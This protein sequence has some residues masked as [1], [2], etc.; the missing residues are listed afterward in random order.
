MSAKILEDLSVLTTIPL[1]SLQRLID[2]SESCICHAVAEDMMQKEPITTV[3]IGIGKLLIKQDTDCIKYKFIPSSEFEDA[4][5]Q[6]VVNKKS[7]LETQVESTL[8]QC[9]LKTY[10]D[11]L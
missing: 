5:I 2:L 4:I 9:I 10:K 6:T 3:N 8:T 1:A 7:P 11:L